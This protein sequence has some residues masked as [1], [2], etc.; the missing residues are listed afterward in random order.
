L[1][2]PA[3]PEPQLLEPQRLAASRLQ[4]PSVWPVAALAAALAVAGGIGLLGAGS[5]RGDAALAAI[6]SSASTSSFLVPI[7]A[8]R[9]EVFDQAIANLRLSDAEKRHIRAEV[10]ADRLRLGVTFAWDW[11]AEDGDVV[12]LASAGFVQT[13]ALTI[14]PQ[15]V[16]IPYESAGA[17]LLVTGIHDGDGGG[18]TA[19]VGSPANPFQLRALFTGEVMQV[20]LP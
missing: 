2:T 13:V 1:P 14:A 10:L 17:P 11:D 15:I 8:T 9:P 20:G 7:D 18:I 6:V 4:L 12:S 5:H 16:V 3:G 19:A